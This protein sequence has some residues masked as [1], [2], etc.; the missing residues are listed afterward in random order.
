MLHE[1]KVD[2]GFGVHDREAH[3]AAGD[4]LDVRGAGLIGCPVGDE[5]HTP[6]EEVGHDVAGLKGEA[7]GERVSLDRCV[8]DGHVR[9][10]GAELDKERGGGWA[11][12]G[13]EEEEEEW[14]VAPE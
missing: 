6:A 5:G 9:V 3:G 12:G 14:K 1:E 8:C 2:A 11:A 10:G 7:E 4:V 13:E